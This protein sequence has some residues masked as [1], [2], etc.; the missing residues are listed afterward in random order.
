MARAHVE[1]IH[2]DD[3]AWSPAALP[4][5]QGV[6]RQKILSMDWETKAASIYMQF[7]AGWQRPRG[8]HHADTEYYVVEGELKVEARVLYPGCYFRAPK[9]LAVGPL[10]S[11]NGCTLLYYREGP[12]GYAISERS[13]GKIDAAAT[14]VDTNEMEWDEIF[15]DGPPTGLKIKLLFLDPVT[16]AYSRL[17]R[18]EPGW[19]DHRLAHHPCMEEA[20]TL[21]GDMEYNFGPLQPG[22][23]FYRPPRIKHG[24]FIAGPQGTVWLIRTDGELVNLYTSPEGEPENYDPHSDLAPV[25]AEPVR[26]KSVGEWDG[27]GR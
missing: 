10:S 6:A 26:T 5:S 22:T 3:L 20:F 11:E 7:E 17:I 19:V 4:G 8:Y 2:V 15:V 14:F 25:Q 23:Y 16:K 13:M 21:A 18:A 9:Y 12:A 1:C 24:H 27:D